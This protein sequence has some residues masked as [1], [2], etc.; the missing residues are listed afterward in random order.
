MGHSK[1]MDT[2]GV[3]GHALQGEDTVTAEK[4]NGLFERI[5]TPEKPIEK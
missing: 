1:S 4:V 2:F 5:L 3:Y